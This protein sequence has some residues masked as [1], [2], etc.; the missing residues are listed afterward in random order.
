MET[1][2]YMQA[3]ETTEYDKLFS[4][5]DLLGQGWGRGYIMIPDGHPCREHLSGQDSNDTITGIYWKIT[6]PNGEEPFQAN[7]KV[8]DGIS[9]DVIF[10]G[11]SKMQGVPGRDFNY[12]LNET[13][14]IK[15]LIDSYNK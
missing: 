10:W 13:L 7:R 9:Y 6:C 2:M 1:I 15:K 12:V 3:Y 8:I 4:N 14:K 11:T 5:D